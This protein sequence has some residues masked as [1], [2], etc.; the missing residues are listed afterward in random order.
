MP[1]RLD[2]QGQ[3]VCWHVLKTHTAPTAQILVAVP[4][5]PHAILS[6]GSASASLDFMANVVNMCVIKESM[7]WGAPKTVNVK[8]CQVAMPTQ[9]LVTM[10]TETA[11][12]SPEELEKT[13][14]K[15]AWKDLT[16]L[17]VVRSVLVELEEGV[18]W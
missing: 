16:D 15:I 10:G 1:V 14:L 13:V 3:S 2:S 18:M 5:R 9:H 8:V 7:V 6:P 17:G 12:V 11:F 4:T